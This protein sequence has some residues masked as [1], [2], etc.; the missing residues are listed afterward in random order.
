MKVNA[1]LGQF[2]VN[3][4][5]QG[6]N[7]CNISLSKS[8]TTV[9]MKENGTMYVAGHLGN[10]SIEDLS[11]QGQQKYSKVLE[12]V[13][14]QEKMVEFSYVTYTPQDNMGYDFAVRKFD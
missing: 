8:F 13:G 4:N 10:L 1:N 11:E 3:L 2:S 7:L 9:A 6:K 5:K 12:I 14:D